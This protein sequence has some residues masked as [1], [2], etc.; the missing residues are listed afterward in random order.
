[1][2][3]TTG[4][5]KPDTTRNSPAKQLGYMFAPV[6][7]IVRRLPWAGLQ[8][9]DGQGGDLVRS[10]VRNTLLTLLL[11]RSTSRPTYVF[12]CFAVDATSITVDQPR[13][14]GLREAEMVS[15]RLV[16]N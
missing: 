5:W 2:A 9:G 14:P 11:G 1:M 10:R 12:M 15:A 6:Q 13:S 7:Q 16:S 8:D 3:G 4:I